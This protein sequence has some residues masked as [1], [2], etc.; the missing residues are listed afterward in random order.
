MRRLQARHP[1]GSSSSLVQG[2]HTAWAWSKWTGIE[3]LREHEVEEGGGKSQL[4]AADGS[5]CC[6]ALD[7]MPSYRLFRSLVANVRLAAVGTSTSVFELG[8]GQKF[9]DVRNGCKFPK[10]AN[11]KIVGIT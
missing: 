7:D 9:T 4:V 6:G 1:N 8:L 2:G 3:P 10:R 11:C 5:C